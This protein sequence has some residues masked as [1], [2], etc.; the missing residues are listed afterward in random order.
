MLNAPATTTDTLVT[1]ADR[2][3]YRALGQRLAEARRASGLTQT[4]LAEQLGIAQQTLAHYEMGRLRVAVAL[5]PPLAR[6]LGVTVEDLMG[7]EAPPA[8]RGP[9][10]KLQQQIERIQKL[11]RTQQKFVMQ[12]LDTVLAQQGR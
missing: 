6:A 3:F 1:A 2:D 4:Q 5:M 9:A 11:P 7:E 12:M 8:K 10:P